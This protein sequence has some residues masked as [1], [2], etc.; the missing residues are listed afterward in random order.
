MA[1]GCLT[2]CTGL[3]GQWKTG[4]GLRWG[5]HLVRPAATSAKHLSNTWWVAQSPERLPEAKKSWNILS[6]VLEWP[7][8][9]IDLRE[10]FNPLLLGIIDIFTVFLT[11]K[12]M[13]FSRRDKTLRFQFT[14]LSLVPLTVPSCQERFTT[15]KHRNLISFVLPLGGSKSKSK[16]LHCSIYDQNKQ[17]LFKDYYVLSHNCH[18]SKFSTNHQAPRVSGKLSL[19]RRAVIA[20]DIL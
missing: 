2:L 13:L 14:L 7:I 1:Q 17:T 12:K 8:D 11:K 15:P 20:S 18:T 9:G 6:G 3:C 10:W 5:R 16:I 19:A 4:S